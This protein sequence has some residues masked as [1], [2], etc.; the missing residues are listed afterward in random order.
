MGEMRIKIEDEVLLTR[1]TDLA[2]EHNRSVDQ[3]IIALLQ[4]ALAVR[5]RREDLPAIAARIAAMTP[6]GVKQTDSVEILREVRD[7]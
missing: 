7:N 2:R 6:K 5:P 3:E 4:A 1:L